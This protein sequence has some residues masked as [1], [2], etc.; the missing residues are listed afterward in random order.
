[1]KKTIMSIPFVLL[2]FLAGCGDS[3]NIDGTS[4]VTFKESFNKI[5]LESS[6][7]ELRKEKEA[8]GYVL[9]E[10][11]LEQTDEKELTSIVLNRVFYNSGAREETMRLF[12]NKVNGMDKEDLLDISE[13]AEEDEVY[14]KFRRKLTPF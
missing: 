7:E 2:L 1:M 10:A 12:L 3:N 9:M 14:Q 4:D 11:I 6:K 5:Q 13:D 8:L